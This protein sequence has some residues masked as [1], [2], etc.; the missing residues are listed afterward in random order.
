MKLK[1]LFKEGLEYLTQNEKARFIQKGVLNSKDPPQVK[2]GKYTQSDLPKGGSIVFLNTN[3]N[4]GYAAQAFRVHLPQFFLDHNGDVKIALTPIRDLDDAKAYLR[5]KPDG[6]EVVFTEFQE[7]EDGKKRAGIWAFMDDLNAMDR[8]LV[9][10]TFGK[11]VLFTCLLSLLEK[12][13]TQQESVISSSTAS[14]SIDY[15]S[16][17][18]NRWDEPTEDEIVPVLKIL[19]EKFRQNLYLLRPELG[20]TWWD[21]TRI[22]FMKALY[23]FRPS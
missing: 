12:R 2:L 17:Q 19:K 21:K 10:V 14:L 11:D 4:Q 9:R 6:A 1:Q 22:I 16:L 7:R 20:R 5:T 8:S 23:G 13:L 18:D 15:F 3:R